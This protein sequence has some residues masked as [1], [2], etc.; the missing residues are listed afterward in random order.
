VKSW[1]R[2]IVP[3]RQL[4][5]LFTLTNLGNDMVVNAFFFCGKFDTRVS[6]KWEA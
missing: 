3:L 2:L 1:H 6:L 5:E 4:T